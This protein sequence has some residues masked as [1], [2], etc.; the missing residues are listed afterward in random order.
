M[1]ANTMELYDL[2]QGISHSGAKSLAI[3]IPYFGYSTME[4]A[5]LSG[6]IW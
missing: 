5:V 2:A 1:N 6:E 3:V 4:R